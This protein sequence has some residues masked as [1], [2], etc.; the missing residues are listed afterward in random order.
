MMFYICVNVYIH[1]CIHVCVCAYTHAHVC[2]CIYVCTYMH[3]H[4]LTKGNKGFR[5]WEE[6]TAA[7]PLP[8]LYSKMLRRLGKSRFHGIP[9]ES[10]HE[11]I[12]RRLIGSPE[13]KKIAVG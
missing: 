9:N 7:G 11:V 10:D 5:T 13:K 1:M 6:G 12:S 2:I 4:A 8:Q 3:M